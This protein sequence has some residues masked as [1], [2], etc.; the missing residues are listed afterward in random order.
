MWGLLRSLVSQSSPPLP[1]SPGG[2]LVMGWSKKGHTYEHGE[3]N[4]HAHTHT[5][6]Q[7]LAISAAAHKKTVVFIVVG[8][9]RSLGLGAL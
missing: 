2:G 1:P 8:S 7:I 5:G 3:T 4:T 6:A 9:A